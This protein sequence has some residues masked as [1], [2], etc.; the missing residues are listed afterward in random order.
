[1][2]LSW[3][4]SE[5]G[6]FWPCVFWGPTSFPLWPICYGEKVEGCPD[7]PACEAEDCVARLLSGDFTS[8][9]ESRENLVIL[10]E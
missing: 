1:M 7:L 3:L 5:G 9:K 8:P 4:V 6:K 10:G 2:P